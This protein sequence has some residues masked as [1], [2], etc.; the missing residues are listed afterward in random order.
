MSVTCTSRSGTRKKRWPNAAAA[1]F[2]A[3]LA[4]RKEGVLYD[5]YACVACGGWHVATR[6]DTNGGP[7]PAGKRKKRDAA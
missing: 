1:K 5:A 2:V 4:Q 6:R 7:V 3:D